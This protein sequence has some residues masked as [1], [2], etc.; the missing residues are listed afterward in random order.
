[1]EE[2]FDIIERL[3]DREEV[4]LERDFTVSALCDRIA[5]SEMDINSYLKDNFG[6]TLREMIYVY[7]MCRIRNILARE[8]EDFSKIGAE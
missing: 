6:I 3:L 1:M 8:D 7:D 5:V 2:V 4:F